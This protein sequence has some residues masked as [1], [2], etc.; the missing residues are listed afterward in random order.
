MRVGRFRALLRLAGRVEVLPWVRR[1]FKVLLLL[2]ADHRQRVG[3]LAIRENVETATDLL[4]SVFVGDAAER[5][6]ID[7]VL[8]SEALLTRLN[9]DLLTHFVALLLVLLTCVFL[10]E[11]L[12]VLHLHIDRVVH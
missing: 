8:F 12:W 3:Q 2:F 10:N 6:L 7:A 5:H 11:A 1:L 9:L 4:F